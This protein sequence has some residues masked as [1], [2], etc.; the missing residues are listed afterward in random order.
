MPDE[1]I[2]CIL[3]AALA[4]R[5]RVEKCLREFTDDKRGESIDSSRCCK[6]VMRA[7]RLHKHFQS[8]I[9]SLNAR[10]SGAEWGGMKTTE[11]PKITKF[12]WVLTLG[13]PMTFPGPEADRPRRWVRDV[14]KSRV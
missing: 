2:T 4:T 3:L 10:E 9:S 8:I 6:V 14:S 11:K 13:F 1:S 5:L 7:L 12:V